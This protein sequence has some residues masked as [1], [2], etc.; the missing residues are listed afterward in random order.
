[1]SKLLILGPLTNKKDP[2]KTGGAIVLFEN[3]IEKLNEL[4]IDYTLI[5]TNKENYKNTYIA[6]ISVIS[7]LV[8]KQ[9]GKTHISLHS[10]RDYLIFAPIVIFLSKFFNKKS[11]LRKFGGEAFEHYSKAKGTKK[12]ILNFI[13]KNIDCLFLEMKYLVGNFKP[14]NQNTFWFPNVR[15]NNYLEIKQNTYS[16]KF[17]FISQVKYEK[18]ID[19]I[20]NAF[21]LLDNTFNIDIYGPIVDARYNVNTFKEFENIQY[22][23]ALNSNEVLNTLNKNDVL[24]LPTFYEGEGYPGIIIESYSVSKPVISTK[25]K[26]IVEIVDEKTGI[27]IEPK[28]TNELIDAIKYFNEDNY[29]EFSKNAKEKFKE[30]NSEIQTKKFLNTIGIN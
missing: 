1:M 28:N 18:G 4:K 12:K 10:S 20:I 23:G 8:Y 13:F 30:F 24:I 27:L 14:I 25:W 5:D 29:S 17:I 7:Q 26:G 2:S 15:N 22:K 3:L 21:K 11:S 19:E 9:F 6:Y 16:K